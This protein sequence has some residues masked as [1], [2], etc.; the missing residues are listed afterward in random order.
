MTDMRARP[1]DLFEI[2]DLREGYRKEAGCQIVRDS[3]LPRGLADP[4]LV[5]VDG[6]I[7][8]YAGIWNKHFPGRLTECFVSAEYRPRALEFLRALVRAT[9]AMELEVQTNILDGRN[10]L[11]HSTSRSWV[12]NL[13]FEEGAATQLRVP[14][15]SFRLRREGDVG[16][17]GEWVAEEADRVVGA[18]GWLTHY[19]PPYA[20]LF[21]EVAEDSR[22]RGIG[23]YLV[24][25][26]RRACTRAGQRAAARCD[27]ANEA[28]R[29]TL[30][31]GGLVRCGEIRAGTLDLTGVES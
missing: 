28:S 8:G 17:P 29:R 18:G 20:D 1:A 11:D 16:P 2:A 30:E 7:A 3:I 10:L 5:V 22:G 13:L 15:V 31:R 14:G 12:E 21:M 26:L 6:D 4:Y 25:E 27:P 19:N 24:Q 23:G 9:G